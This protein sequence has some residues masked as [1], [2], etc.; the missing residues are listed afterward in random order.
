M[1]MS[2]GHPYKL[3]PWKSLTSKPKLNI[4]VLPCTLYN[5]TLHRNDAVSLRGTCD[6][7][8]CNVRVANL[9]TG[10]EAEAIVLG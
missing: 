6:R 10:D 4:F 8:T 3:Q 9:M 1:R 7:E 2:Y 5:Q